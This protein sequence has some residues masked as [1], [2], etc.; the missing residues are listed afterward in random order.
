LVE[1]AEVPIYKSRPVR[2]LICIGEV[3]IA[4]ILSV[5]GVLILDVYKDVNWREIVNAK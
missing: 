1:A 5:I 3:F 4:F 2:S